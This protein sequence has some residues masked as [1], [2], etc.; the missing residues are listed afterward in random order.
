MGLAPSSSRVVAPRESPCDGSREMHLVPWLAFALVIITTLAC[1]RAAKSR[2]MAAVFAAVG[3][4]LLPSVRDAGI[5]LALFGMSFVFL[6]V[7]RG[8]EQRP[9][10]LRHLRLLRVFLFRL[11]NN[12]FSALLFTVMFV[13]A[14]SL[15]WV[16]F[17][18]EPVIQDSQA[19]LFH[20]RILAS[21][22]WVAPLPEMPEFFAAEHVITEGAFYSQY[23]PGHIAVLAL[24]VLLGAPSA[25]NPLL[26]ALGLLVLRALGAA[27]YG[28][29]TGRR[30]A[31]LGLLSPFSLF[32]S[33]EYMNHASGFLAFGLVLL[34]T[35]KLTRDK[36]EMALGK[37]L[38][39]SL[40]C[41]LAMGAVVLV[42]PLTGVLCVPIAFYLASWALGNLRRRLLP[43]F[44]IGALGLGLS[45]LLLQWNALTTGDPF[46]WGY[47]VRWGP[48]HTLGFGISPWG[49]PHTPWLGLQHSLSNFDAWNL[50][51][52][53][54][55]LPALFFVALGVER[56]RGDALT[57][58]LVVAPL[59]L[60]AIHFA[61]FFQ[62]LTFG[63]R[64]LYEGSVIAFLLAARGIET[65]PAHVA[66]WRAVSP[67]RANR[68]TML[69]IVLSAA[70]A[71]G[72]VF[73]GLALEYSLTYAAYGRVVEPAQ[74]LVQGERAVIFVEDLQDAGY[75][76]DPDAAA[77]ILFVLDLGD[78]NNARFV[79]AHAERAAFTHREGRFERVTCSR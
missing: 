59:A 43:L 17:H 69:G 36:H 8:C 76:L 34:A 33:S 23:P 5:V 73:P 48:E 41:G 51:L 26:G 29:K 52:F 10:R 74:A 9:W 31:L 3:V 66:A 65:L 55:P 49:E 32:M 4:T 15:S 57:W 21:G 39:W 47:I 50:F 42:R 38:G 40:V 14:W 44:V 61:Y 75:A 53:G 28:E 62:D 2:S 24:G 58:A 68:L 27:L 1:M 35:A 54:G 20:A 22:R 46:L 70:L 25:I 11:S 13:L 71:L 78:A 19:Q 72:T 45:L 37:A 16:L 63:P 64:Y 6:L 7:L 67:Q 30:A 79:C 56:D 77:P 12:T 60:V 18:G